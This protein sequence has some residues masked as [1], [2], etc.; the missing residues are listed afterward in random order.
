MAAR[1]RATAVSFAQN[2]TQ[3]VSRTTK[4]KSSVRLLAVASNSIGTAYRCVAQATAPETSAE[5][6]SARASRA[7]QPP[8]IDP[9]TR[10]ALGPACPPRRRL[11][12]SSGHPS[13]I[14]SDVPRLD[15]PRIQGRILTGSKSIDAMKP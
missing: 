3:G 8:R 15:Q 11:V 5:N 4:E 14:S 1:P 2:Q 13:S 10:H 7:V 12:S 9:A 6:S